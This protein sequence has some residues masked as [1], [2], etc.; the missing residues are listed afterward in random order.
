MSE[1]CKPIEKLSSK[2][3]SALSNRQLISRKDIA[4]LWVCFAGA[5]GRKFI[6]SY[7]EKDCGVWYEALSDLTLDDLVYGLKRVLTQVTEHERKSG[8]AWPPNVKEFRLLC[9]RTLEKFGLPS[10]GKAFD[11]YE[12]GQYVQSGY[13]L[14][15]VIRRAGQLTLKAIDSEERCERYSVFKNIYKKLANE[16]MMQQ[17]AREVNATL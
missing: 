6:S 7:G 16:Y 2:K 11:E 3:T 17:R 4:W 5:Y 13:W 9:E 10:V 15:P 14:H 1:P 8:E 12:S